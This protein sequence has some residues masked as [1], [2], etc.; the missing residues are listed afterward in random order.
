MSLALTPDRIVQLGYAFREAR[1]LMSAA[2][3]GVFDALAA[4]PLA[5][6]AL[7]N[8]VAIHK[9]GARDFFDALVALGLLDRDVDGRYVNTRAA[10]LHLVRGRPG[11][12]GGLLDHLSSREYPYWQTLS[13]A[14]RS[15]RAQFDQ[16]GSG[17]YPALYEN[18]T[19]VESFARA[20]TGG[21]LLA[22][23]ALAAR[24][25]WRRYQTV[26]DVGAAEGCALVE[27]A[28]AHR[29]LTGVGF[30][31]PEVGPSFER[32]VKAHELSE[33]L[34]FCSGDFLNDSLPGGDVMI[35][36]RVLHN[37][38]LATK[39]MLLRKAFDA[40][41]RNGVL[42]VYE[43]LIDDERRRGSAGLLASLNMLIM[44]DSGFDFTG[45][46]CVR[47]MG[48]TG[49]GDFDIEELT[50]DHTMVVATKMHSLTSA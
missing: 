43:R 3:L 50:A 27:I 8:R 28:R 44:T 4:G 38:D 34:R 26:I 46:D 21:S 10:D 20:M 17:H 9:R 40:L 25:P 30:D 7:G 41:P 31:L 23:R 37:W 48:E 14:L 18:Q 19:N 42:V 49:F 29:H 35:M 15:G 39:K 22:A 11:Y 47:W 2:E 1:A 24:F 13:D 6:D 32:Y 36:G 5:L 12:I 33:R 45:A 16:T